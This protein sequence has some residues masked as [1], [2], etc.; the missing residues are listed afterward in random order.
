[1]WH[2]LSTCSSLFPFFPWQPPSLKTQL[3]HPCGNLPCSVFLGPALGLSAAFCTGCVPDT[4]MGPQSCLLPA[5]SREPGTE[6]GDRGR[7]RELVRSHQGSSPDS[8]GYWLAVLGRW[9][10]GSPSLQGQQ[11]RGTLFSKN[12][13]W[14]QLW[15]PALSYPLEPQ[16]CQPRAGHWACKAVGEA[17]RARGSQLVTIPDP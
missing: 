2:D 15:V 12:H 13:S 9:S 14:P 6:A 7:D 8:I 4:G 11:K 3:L 16:G 17:L 1:M 10:K 5:S